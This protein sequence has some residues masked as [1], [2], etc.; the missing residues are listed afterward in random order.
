MK[1]F[2]NTMGVTLVE[3]LLA[4]FILAAAVLP[5]S[6]LFSQYYSITTRQLEREIAQKLAEGAMEA[7]MTHR[8]SDL[9]GNQDFTVPL[10]I[11]T[12]GG[13]AQFDLDFSQNPSLGTADEHNVEAQSERFRIGRAEYGVS[14]YV[15]ILFKAQNL[16][17]IHDDALVLSYGFDEFNNGN[18]E[19]STYH[20][21]D[22]LITI[23]VDVETFTDQTHSTR[24]KSFRADMTR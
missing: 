14:V 4:L 22:N 21:M 16:N 15:D 11:N 18:L 19:V 2:E 1:Q 5:I 8:Y 13:I 24:L 12:P 7:L 20:S 9:V 17:N 3:I 10:S 6:G 23:S